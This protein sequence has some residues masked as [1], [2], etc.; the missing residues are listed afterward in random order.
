[1]YKRPYFGDVSGIAAVEFA[2]LAPILLFIL[3]GTIDVGLYMNDK[4]RL[5]AIS[6]AAV[7]YLIVT[8]DEE[9]VMEEVI[10]PYYDSLGEVG[11]EAS[12]ELET[13]MICECEGGEPVECALGFC[14][15]EGDYKRRFYQVN[16]TKTHD[17]LFVYPGFDAE[18]DLVGSAKMQLD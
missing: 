7:E 2:F 8:R 6:R 15:D 16:V 18:I 11:W 9:T 17:T 14:P 4:M 13:E 5:E 1:M 12:F 10:A 3:I